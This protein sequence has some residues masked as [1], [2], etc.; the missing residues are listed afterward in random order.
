MDKCYPNPCF[1][2]GVCIVDEESG[3]TEC[4]CQDGYI[5]DNCEI[6][7]LNSDKYGK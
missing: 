2:D 7:K 3:E 1:H 4:E 5:G 6:G